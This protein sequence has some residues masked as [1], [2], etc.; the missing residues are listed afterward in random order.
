M[1]LYIIVGLVFVAVALTVAR[2]LRPARPNAEKLSSYE[3]GED[4]QGSA[5]GQFNIRFY[6]IALVFLLFEVE[7]VLLF[8]W[9]TVFGRADLVQGTN[10]LWGWFS[11]AEVTLF[12]LILALGLA[13]V[14]AKGF[15][16]W[17]KPTVNTTHTQSP[18]PRHLYEAL[19]RKEYKKAPAPQEQQE[20]VLANNN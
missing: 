1:L 10:G 2:L 18:V 9:A 7:I 5:W 14:W 11:L 20:Q 6:I 4:A 12:V 16:N 3:C 13:Y 17:Q 19:N 8:P 15:L